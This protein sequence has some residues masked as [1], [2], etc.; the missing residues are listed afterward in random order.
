MD[1]DNGGSYVEKV[2]G[3]YYEKLYL[4]KG[5]VYEEKRDRGLKTIVESTLFSIMLLLEALLSKTI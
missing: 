1:T 3:R 5:F 4:R 2:M